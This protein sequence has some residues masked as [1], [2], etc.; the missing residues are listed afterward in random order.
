MTTELVLLG[1]FSTM[2][3]LLT[4]VAGLG[5]GMLLLALM[6]QLFPPAVLIPLHGVAQFF[7]NANRGWI[8]RA[9][10]EWAYLKP[11]IL[12]SAIGALAFVPLV[13]FVNPKIGALAIG[14]FIL[15]VT[16]F[17]HWLKVSRLHPFFSGGLISGLGVL[18]GATGPLAMSAHPKDNWNKEQIVG[19]HGAAMAFQHGAKV[20]AYL[21]AGVALYKY[22][23]HIVV[24]FF[25]AWLGTFMGTQL[26]KKFTDDRFKIILKWV[27]TALAIRLIV[28]NGYE[29]L[30]T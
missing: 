18:F 15:V 26:L 4:A 20:V 29:L 6:A 21:V 17:P 10:L 1:L 2:T 16:W 23:P 7:S 8:H 28:L 9:K 30:T 27:L 25:G 14:L 24:L 3:S 19:N 22:L 13:V 11:F 5:G 12:G